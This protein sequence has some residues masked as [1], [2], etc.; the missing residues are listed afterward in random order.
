MFPNKPEIDE[1]EYCK[2]IAQNAL[3]LLKSVLQ[4]HQNVVLTESFNIKAT[5]LRAKHLT[6]KRRAGTLRT[7]EI[8]H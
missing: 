5:I 8:V 4:S 6:Y 2:Q 1:H 7:P 3:G